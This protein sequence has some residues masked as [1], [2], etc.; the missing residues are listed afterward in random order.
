MQELAI[1]IPLQVW[2]DPQGDVVLKHSR[3]ECIIYFGCWLSAGEP[4][5]YVCELIFDHAWAIRGYRSEYLPY[6][7]KQKGSHSDIYEIENSTWLKQASE[8][9][10][11]SYPNWQSWD[12]KIYHHYV[13]QGHDN[14]YEL[15]AAGYTEKKVPYHEAGELTNL[16]VTGF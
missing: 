1:P 13:V 14:Y 16:K 9:R 6:R 15:L 12:K 10:A 4:A 3:S 5:G 7:L 11:R 8:Q 2:L